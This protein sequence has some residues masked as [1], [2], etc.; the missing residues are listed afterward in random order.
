MAR[1]NEAIR[2]Y[3]AARS[4][5]PEVAHTLAHALDQNGEPDQAI[6]LFQELTRLRPNTGRHFR[7]LGVILRTRGRAPEAAKVT[8]AALKLLRE[9]VR[10]RPE[11]IRAA[12]SL[13]RALTEQ[14]KHQEAI[15][16]IKRALQI[17]PDDVDLHTALGSA[18]HAAGKIDAAIGELGA[19]IQ[20]DPKS[21]FA[22]AELAN[23][24][25][26][27]KYDYAAAEAEMRE[28]LRL[29]PENHSSREKMGDILSRQGKFPEAIR[30]LRIAASIDPTCGHVRRFLG[31]ALRAQGKLEEALNEYRESLRRQPD[32]ESALYQFDRVMTELGRV[33]ALLEEYR[34]MLRLRPES[35]AVLNSIA[36]NLALPADRPARGYDEALVHARKCVELNPKDGN[37]VN[38]LALAEYRVGH[39]HESIAAAERSIS[40][41]RGGTALDWFI[42]AMSHSRTGE[43]EKARTWFDKAVAWTK[44]KDPKNA[45]LLQFWKEAAKLLAVPGPPEP[46]R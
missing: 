14:R 6:A 9:D 13:G 11:D 29:D 46:E 16:E 43:N 38:T 8:E 45:E 17:R 18:L 35:D 3:T 37:H 1:R 41:Q 40:L 12:A 20:L 26:Y 25:A 5:R 4:I 10:Q 15:D 31:D 44:E 23:A 39:W 2:F 21:S 27:G 42:L 36:W 22:H 19:A 7:C 34:A 24:L 28:S 32:D 33:D 30:E